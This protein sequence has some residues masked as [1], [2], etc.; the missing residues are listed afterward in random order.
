[1]YRCVKR[2]CMYVYTYG[3]ILNF[4]CM[5]VNVICMY[6]ECGACFGTYVV[7]HESDGGKGRGVRVC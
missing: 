3:Y 1:M 7:C 6:N 2:I 4:I 5:Y